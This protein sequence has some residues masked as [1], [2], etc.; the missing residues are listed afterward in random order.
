[1]ST[2]NNFPKIRF[3]ILN[4]IFQKQILH[5]KIIYILN[6]NKIKNHFLSILMHINHFLH[7]FLFILHVPLHELLLTK[8]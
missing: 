6:M 1:M 2:L 7:L 5:Y 4:S 3:G 8:V